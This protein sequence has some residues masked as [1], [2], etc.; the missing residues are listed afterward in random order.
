MQ[1]YTCTIGRK[2]NKTEYCAQYK[3]AHSYNVQNTPH[4]AMKLTN[5]FCSTHGTC[6]I[7]KAT[8]LHSSFVAVYGGPAKQMRVLYFAAVV[9]VFFLLFFVA[10]SQRSQ[11]GCLRRDKEL[12]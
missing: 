10:Y 1:D 5:E 6:Y 4:L 11:N 8:I 3:I 9:S 2:L 12:N 7:V